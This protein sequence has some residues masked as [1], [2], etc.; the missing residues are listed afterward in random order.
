M[1]EMSDGGIDIDLNHDLIVIDDRT[2]DNSSQYGGFG[3]MVQLAD[4][5]FITPYSHMSLTE[6]MRDVF[7]RK[8]YQDVEWFRAYSAR[9]GVDWDQTHE[10]FYERWP[11][12]PDSVKRADLLR[13]LAS[14]TRDAYYRMQVLRWRFR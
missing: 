9:C 10:G 6:F 7:D 8:L 2:P 11:S 1:R 14:Q 5:T 12:R 3:R 4:G 13:P